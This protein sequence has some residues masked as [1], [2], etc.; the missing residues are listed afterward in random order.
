MQLPLVY[1]LWPDKQRKE[2]NKEQK[3]SVEIAIKNKFQLIQG[4]P[5]NDTIMSYIVICLMHCKYFMM[6]RWNIFACIFIQLCF[7]NN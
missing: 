7:D 6:H 5:G 4:P 3:E 2:L 1:K